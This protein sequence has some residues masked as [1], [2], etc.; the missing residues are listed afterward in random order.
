MTMYSGDEYYDYDDGYSSSRWGH[1]YG[2]ADSDEPV[3]HDESSSTETQDMLIAN[4]KKAAGEQGDHHES[5]SYLFNGIVLKWSIQD[6]EEDNLNLLSGLE[7]LPTHYERFSQ[8][9]M[10]EYYEDFK[11]YILEDARATIASGLASRSYKSAIKY[12]FTL[13]RDVQMSK[14]P[15]NPCKME[16]AQD[17][18]EKVD[19]KSRV[20]V[21]LKPV[22]KEGV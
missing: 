9:A 7:D 17:I 8:G 18:L 15:K 20:A 2:Y 6:I 14:N 4:P 12:N 3:D 19:G 13:N 22:K 1:G 5:G 16:L 21:L 10:K 11:P